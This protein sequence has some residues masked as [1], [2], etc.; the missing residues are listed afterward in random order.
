MEVKCI[1]TGMLE[2]NCYFLR[3]G[4]ETAVIDPG[5]ECE[6]LIKEANADSCNIKMI[7]LTHGHFDH[8]GAVSDMAKH[9]GAKVYVHKDDAVMLTDNSKNLSCMTGEKITPYT[10]DV[11]LSGGEE[12]KLGNATIK[13][14]HTPGHSNGCVTY[15]CGDCLFCGDL[16]FKGSIG[17]FERENLLKHMNSLS[18]VTQNFDDNKKVYPGHGPFTTIGEEKRENPYIINHIRE[19]L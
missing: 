3:V 11:L 14:H 10:P 16:L 4:D 8:I 17:N 7:L 13:V 2:E 1:V 15:E 12:L 6:K 9:T 19:T 18:Y 5:A